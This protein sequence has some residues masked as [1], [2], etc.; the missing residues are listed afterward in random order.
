MDPGSSVVSQ[1]AVQ[2]HVEGAIR[3]FQKAGVCGPRS[4]TIDWFGDLGACK[5]PTTTGLCSGCPSSAPGLGS[6]LSRCLAGGRWHERTRQQV[7]ILPFGPL[8]ACVCV[9]DAGAVGPGGGRHVDGEPRG[10]RGSRLRADETWGCLFGRACNLVG[11][12][13]QVRR[14]MKLFATRLPL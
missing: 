2:N 14:H 12:D 7:R 8:G 3:E 13:S 10:V 6:A 1:F 9:S 4:R 5:S 11:F